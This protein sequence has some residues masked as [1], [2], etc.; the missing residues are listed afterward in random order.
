MF[1]SSSQGIP[2]MM[3]GS[4]S[5]SYSSRNSCML[6]QRLSAVRTRGV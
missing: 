2:R 4:C 6:K 3:T 1:M 5:Y